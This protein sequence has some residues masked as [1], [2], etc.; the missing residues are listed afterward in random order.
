MPPTEEEK[1]APVVHRGPLPYLRDQP[2]YDRRRLCI[3]L[4]MCRI[5]S[6]V[7][8]S[9]GCASPGRCT[10]PDAARSSSGTPFVSFSS[11]GPGTTLSVCV[12]LVPDVLANAMPDCLM[13]PGQLAVGALSSV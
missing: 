3:A 5:C 13:L 11:T 6:F 7:P 9:G 2:G 12:G 4:T 1:R 10:D 8:A